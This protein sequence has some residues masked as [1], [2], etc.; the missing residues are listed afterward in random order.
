MTPTLELA[1]RALCPDFLTSSR[2]IRRSETREVSGGWLAAGTVARRGVDPGGVWMLQRAPT[3]DAVL[4]HRLC[5]IPSGGV[6][7]IS[8]HPIERQKVGGIS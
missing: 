3:W 6:G 4:V 5:M 1:R 2:K 7:R 8:N